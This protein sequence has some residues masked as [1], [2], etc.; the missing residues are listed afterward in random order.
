MGRV[1]Q[2]VAAALAAVRQRVEGLTDLFVRGGAGGPRGDAERAAAER[3]TR[4]AKGHAARVGQKSL[5]LFLSRGFCAA[6][7]LSLPAFL[8][9]SLPP[10]LSQRVDHHGIRP[11]HPYSY[12]S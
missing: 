9:P 4:V 6:A 10:F 7:P 11:R 8:P 12:T 2:S 5:P 3:I 1:P